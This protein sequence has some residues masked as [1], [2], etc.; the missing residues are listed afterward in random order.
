MLLAKLIKTLFF[1]VLFFGFP[2]LNARAQ[3]PFGVIINEV[4]WMGTSIA[5]V[6]SKNWW[7]YEWLELYNQKDESIS[8]VGWKIELWRETLDWSLELKGII[9]AKSYFLIVASDKAFENYDLNYSNLGGKLN[10]SGQRVV[11]KD[12]LGNITDSLDCFAYKKWFAG[13][14]ETKQTME[15]INPAVSGNNPSNWQASRDSGG[16]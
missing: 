7:R 11:L 9:P 14:N 3:N 10:N 4:A 8:L 15:R 12:G 16:T 5:G 6:E 2:F 13:N 1:A